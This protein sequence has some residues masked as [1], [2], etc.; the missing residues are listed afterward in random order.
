[1]VSGGQTQNPS[2]EDILDAIRSLASP[3]VIVLPNN[4]N[5]IMAAERA[6]ELAAKELGKKVHVLPTKTI[7]EGLAAAVLF[8]ENRPAE[9]LIPEMEEAAR[10]TRTLEVTRASRAAQV[11]GVGEE[12][13]VIGLLDGKLKVV[14]ED[15]NEALL[16]LLRLVDE[17]DYEILTLFY[18]PAVDKEKLEELE[19]K[20]SEEFPELEL[21]LHPGGPD[22]YDYV[23][24]L[25]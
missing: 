4:K 11:E 6:A 8:D 9:E 22:L 7:G 1:V 14:A 13:Q 24:V 12:G 5:V 17:G 25:E 19:E 2:V 15:P 21:E 3:E 18:A 10:A 23:A 16:D 20:I